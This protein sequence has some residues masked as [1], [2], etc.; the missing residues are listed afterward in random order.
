MLRV[1]KSECLQTI[2][3]KQSGT[4]N[5][6]SFCVFYR[7]NSPSIILYCSQDSLKHRGPNYG[8]HSSLGVTSVM[9]IGPMC[10]YSTSTSGQWW[11]CQENGDNEI[12]KMIYSN[13][14]GLNSPLCLS[15]TWMDWEDGR[16]LVVALGPLVAQ[17]WSNW[18]LQRSR[19]LMPMEIRAHGALLP[20]FC[21]GKSRQL[22]VHV[23]LCRRNSPLAISGCFKV[24]L[25]FY[26]GA[27]GLE[28]PIPTFL[29]SQQML[30]VY[31]KKLKYFILYFELTHKQ[32]MIKAFCH[33][34]AGFTRSEV[35]TEMRLTGFTLVLSSNH[36]ITTECDIIEHHLLFPL[37]TQNW[38][39]GT[40]A[41]STTAPQ[42][43]VCGIPDR[44]SRGD[45][46]QDRGALAKRR[47]D[48]ELKE[49]EGA[50]VW[51]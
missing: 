31:A 33:W 47:G 39:A 12:A 18:E 38:V 28:N 2:C 24:I 15:S 20:P 9:K 16:E 13:L 26:N 44:N 7:G 22:V 23:H 36:K 29:F 43:W 34:R 17:L 10:F 51:Y 3:P 14:S 32:L 50:A 5:R 30:D 21:W 37:K 48:P 25:C 4:L 46:G 45:A 1:H 27:S 49:Q 40:A 41:S 6:A 8:P 11:D 35:I 19:D 42:S